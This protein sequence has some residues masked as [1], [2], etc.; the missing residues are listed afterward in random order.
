MYNEQATT[1]MSGPPLKI[2]MFCITIEHKRVATIFLNI[3][4][5]YYQ[6]PILGILNMSRHFDQKG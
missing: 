4:E 2:W 3:L 1:N 5:K 6:L